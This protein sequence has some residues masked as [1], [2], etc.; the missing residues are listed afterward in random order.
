MNLLS[1]NFKHFNS[2]KTSCDFDVSFTGGDQHKIS[3]PLSINLFGST[4]GDYYYGIIRISNGI[5]KEGSPSY[6]TFF[7]E[8][9][10]ITLDGKKVHT[11]GINLDQQIILRPRACWE[12][13]FYI[14]LKDEN[15]H[16]PAGYFIDDYVYD[17][18]KKYGPCDISLPKLDREQVRKNK[19]FYSQVLTNISSAVRNGATFDSGYNNIAHQFKMVGPFVVEGYANGYAHGGY[20]IDPNHGWEG[21]K[22]G[23]EYHAWLAWANMNRQF[24]DAIDANGQPKN[25]YSWAKAPGRDLMKGQ[26]GRESEVELVYFLEGDYENRKYNVFNTISTVPAYSD[27]LWF[28]RPNDTA[29]IIRVVRH[30]IP[31]IEHL[32]PEHPYSKCAKFDLQMIFED[33]R[34]QLWSDRT[35]ELVVPSYPGE[36]LPN[37]LGRLLN[38]NGGH[39]H[40]RLERNSAWMAYLGACTLKYCNNKEIGWATNMGRAFTHHSDKFGFTHRDG[41]RQ[42]LNGGYGTKIFHSAL[43]GIGAYSLFKQLRNQADPNLAMPRFVYQM[44]HTMYFTCTPTEYTYGGFGPTHWCQTA[45]PDGQDLMSPVW[46]G[47]GDPA[48]VIAFMALIANEYP[49]KKREW[50]EMSL[51]FLNPSPT[52]EDRYASLKAMQEKS[53]TADMEAVLGKYLGKY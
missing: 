24:C 25:L 19:S 15:I 45:S 12:I 31:L 21:C 39:A 23:V 26:I 37:S 42:E 49:R 32:N 33:C 44:A 11:Y 14:N 10:Q 38:D 4:K 1:L 40:P 3:V 46:L 5:V 43:V 27:E 9:L 8:G 30:L 22:E 16:P 20:G 34:Y 52:L 47:D 13:P 51:K 35:D 50:L 7:A 29:H 18:N 6:G 53:W 36:W 17:R 2:L 28:Y 48:H 41:P